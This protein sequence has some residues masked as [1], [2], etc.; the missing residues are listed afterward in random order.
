MATPLTHVSSRGARYAFMKK[1]LTMWMKAKKTIRFAD[2]EWMER[3]SHPNGTVVMRNS[4]D[5]NAS[6]AEGR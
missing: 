5:S 2:H 1:T 3:I 4:T 6:S